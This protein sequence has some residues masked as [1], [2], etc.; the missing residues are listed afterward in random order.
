[1]AQRK[2]VTSDQPLADEQ[3]P[4]AEPKC[5]RCGRGNDAVLGEVT[6]DMWGSWQHASCRYWTEQEVA[7]WR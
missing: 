7:Q 5:M 3:L 6:R 2:P 4:A 1:M